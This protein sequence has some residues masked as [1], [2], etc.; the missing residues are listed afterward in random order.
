MEKTNNH[1]ICKFPEK[2]SESELAVPT[3]IYNADLS[4]FFSMP[5]LEDMNETPG[6]TDIKFQKKN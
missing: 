2:I 4:K 3:P 1:E 5:A 6:N